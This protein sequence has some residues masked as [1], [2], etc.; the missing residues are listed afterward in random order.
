MIKLASRHLDKQSTIVLLQR[1]WQALAG[2]VT[3]ILVASF[4]TPVE[5]GYFY[6]LLSLAALYMAFDLGLSTVLIQ[7]SA[8]HFIDLSWGRTGRACGMN[9]A[10]FLALL[11]LSI[12]WYAVGAIIFL[13]LYPLGYFLINQEGSELGYAWQIPWLLLGVFTAVVLLLL[14]MQSI[15]EGSGSIT[16]VYTVKLIAA[17]SGSVLAWLLLIFGGGIYAVVA[18]PFAAAAINFIWLVKQR[19][20]ML[21]QA[22]KVNAGHIN[23]GQDIWP[24]QWKIAASW[25][26]G[27]VTV[28]MHTPLLFHFQGAVV[29]GQMGVTMTIAN[30]ISLLSLSWITARV[31]AMTTAVAEKDWQHLDQLFWRAFRLSIAAFVVFG[32]GFVLVRVLLQQYT[33]YGERFLPVDESIG[34]MLAILLYHVIGLFVTYL[35]VHMQEP[36]LLPSLLGVAIIS[37]SV[38]MFAAPVWGSKG[39]VVVLLLV[40]G[41]IL[42]PTALILWWV[43][44]RKWHS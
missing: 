33:A 38:L 20:L 37:V 43:L 11:R 42:L 7:F 35:R 26:A 15:V 31:P 21:F 10:P 16:E 19:R 44:K 39:V 41:L 18:L 24:L 30:M 40:N 23:W 14:P 4:L 3:L 13:L 28:S 8:R 34:L 1:L 2:G 6:T 12:Y 9:K 32:L 17:I 5:Q 25:L 22:A 29:A 36:F 27:Y